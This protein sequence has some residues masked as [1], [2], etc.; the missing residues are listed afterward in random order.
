MMIDNSA[1]TLPNNSFLLIFI[2]III[3]NQK[4]TSSKDNPEK[5]REKCQTQKGTA[6]LNILCLEYESFK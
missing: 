5:F 4:Y 2:V 1:K 6:T 3:S